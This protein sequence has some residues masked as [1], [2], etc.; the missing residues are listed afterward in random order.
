[1]KER[2]HI[3]SFLFGELKAGNTHAFDK[4]FNDHYQNLCR[5]ANSIV[6]DLDT[7]QSLVQN[8]FV[9]L[10][11]NHAT[12]NHIDQLFPYLTSMV[13][14]HCI[15]FINREKRNTIVPDFPAE[16]Q[17][18]NTTENQ[19]DLNELEEKLIVALTALPER[20]KMAFEYSRF[21]NLTNNEIAQKMEITTKGVEALIGRALKS[22]RISLV[23]YLPSSKCAKLPDIILFGLFSKILKPKELKNTGR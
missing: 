11:E 2:E 8:V 7:A 4:I 14:N 3:D 17:T 22:L 12:L 20:C 10:W 23:E 6:H 13:R 19:L 5:F 9:K 1:M 18:G 15:N 16:A 21:E